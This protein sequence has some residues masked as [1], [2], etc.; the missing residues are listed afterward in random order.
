MTLTKFMGGHGTTLGGIIV[1][2]GSLVRV[3]VT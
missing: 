1:D 2:S 3:S